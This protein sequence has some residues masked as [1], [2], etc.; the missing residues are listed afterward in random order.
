MAAESDQ[1][2]TLPATP[3]RLEQAREEGQ[4]ARSR[5]LGACAVVLSG[6]ALAWTAGSA[7]V[8]YS[9][10]LMRAGL[11]VDRESAFST[12]AVGERFLSLGIDAFLGLVPLLVTVVVI[13][14]LSALLIGG[15]LY[16]PRAFQPDLGRMS[17]LKWVKRTFSAEG[18]AELGKAVAKALLVGTIGCLFLWLHREEMLGLIMLEP[19]QG[20]AE[21]GGMVQGS[22]LALAAALALIALIDVPLVL[23]KHHKGLRMSLE[24]VK[25]EM[26]ESEGDPQLKARIRSQ[27]REVARRRMMAEVPK[28]DVVVTNPTHFSVALAYREGANGAPRVLAKGRGEIAL[29]IRELAAAHEVPLLEA[30][31]LARA[32]YASCELGD[33]IPPALYH[34]VARVL[35]YVYQLRRYRTQGGAYPH[36][37]QDLEVPEGMDPGAPED[38]EGAGR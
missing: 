38:E 20:L 37:P 28:A 18:L 7:A 26:K 14:I 8:D 4:V 34:T 11:T 3:R 32:L 33:E 22:L 30:P 25:R 16:S 21:F 6:A 23:W 17:P 24:E 35:A 15:W 13:A 2:K 12:A 36:E 5:E 9:I 27:Q 1:E 10:R 31:P 19:G 29:K